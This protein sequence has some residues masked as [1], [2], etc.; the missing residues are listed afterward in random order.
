M[1]QWKKKRIFNAKDKI[2]IL[3]D[4]LEAFQSKP[5]PCFF[6]IHNTKRELLQAYREEEIHWNKKKAKINGWLLGTETPNSFTI[7]LIPIGPGNTLQNWEMMWATY[8]GRMQQKRRWLLPTSRSSFHRQIVK[9]KILWSCPLKN[10]TKGDG[11]NERSSHKRHFERRGE[12]S[13]ILNQSWEC[14]RTGWYVGVV[15]PKI[16]GCY[17]GRH[18]KGDLGCLWN[19]V[20]PCGLKLYISLPVTKNPRPG[21][22]DGPLTD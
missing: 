11:K 2:H 17:W 19:G 8:S 22:D 18:N 6:A 10:D 7:R 13:D 20:S 1:S 21:A 14:T 4:R 5:Y 16:L 9:S 12:R 3:Q 15:L